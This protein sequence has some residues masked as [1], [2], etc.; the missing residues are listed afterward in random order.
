MQCALNFIIILS[1]AVVFIAYVC[2]KSQDLLASNFKPYKLETDQ[3]HFFETD[4]DI[5]NLFHRI[6]PA[7]DIRLATD[8]DIPT[9]LT[10][11]FA[12]IVT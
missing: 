11:M 3:Y 6:W 9:L 2:S 10:N 1:H 12:D 7:T 4:T 5:F 8:T